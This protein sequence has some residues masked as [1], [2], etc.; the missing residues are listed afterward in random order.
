MKLPFPA[1]HQLCG[2]TAIKTELSE[3]FRLA[4]LRKTAAA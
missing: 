4:G 2:P 3:S 1:L